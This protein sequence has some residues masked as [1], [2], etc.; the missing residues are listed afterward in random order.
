MNR[1]GGLLDLGDRNRPGSQEAE[2]NA[3]TA[4][5]AAITMLPTSDA[6]RADAE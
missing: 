5:D 2:H 3:D 6:P 1:N 4:W